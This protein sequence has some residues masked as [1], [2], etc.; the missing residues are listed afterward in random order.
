MHRSKTLKA[1]SVNY[2]VTMMRKVRNREHSK[3]VTVTVTKQAH[4]PLQLVQNVEKF[5]DAGYVSF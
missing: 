2:A 5:G 3:I 4:R 1:A